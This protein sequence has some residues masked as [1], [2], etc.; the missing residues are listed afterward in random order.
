MPD[1]RVP[2]SI[3]IG[4]VARD[5]GERQSVQNGRPALAAVVGALERACVFLSCAHRFSY[6]ASCPN[7]SITSTAKTFGMRVW[8]PHYPSIAIVRIGLTSETDVTI[9][10]TV[11]STAGGGG[12]SESIEVPSIIE[13]VAEYEWQVTIGD[14]SAS[15]DEETVE[16]VLDRTAGGELTRLRY[17]TVVVVPENPGGV[18]S[19]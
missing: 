13:D 9:D 17:W 5:S 6:G 14:G 11:S 12:I 7:E 15:V 2:V 18:V 19:T 8:T 16:L 4:L 1:V 10:V 3:P